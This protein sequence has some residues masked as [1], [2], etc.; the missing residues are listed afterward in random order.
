VLFAETRIEVVLKLLAYD[1]REL[2]GAEIPFV[3]M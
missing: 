2:G 1:Q 3:A